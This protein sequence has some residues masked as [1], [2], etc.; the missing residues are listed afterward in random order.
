MGKALL[1]GERSPHSTTPSLA[2]RSSGLLFDE[3]R[4]SKFCDHFSHLYKTLPNL[5]FSGRVMVE[6]EFSSF[7]RQ[8]FIIL[9]IFGPSK[10]GVSAIV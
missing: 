4:L 6:G 1:H 3:C 7:G 10:F 2:L 5:S 9:V 8:T